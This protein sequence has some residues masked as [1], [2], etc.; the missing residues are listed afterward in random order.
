MHLGCW[1]RGGVGNFASF[2]NVYVFHDCKE[3]VIGIGEV[4][5]RTQSRSGHRSDEGRLTYQDSNPALQPVHTITSL[6]DLLRRIR[7]FVLS[8]IPGMCGSV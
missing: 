7:W 4:A 2:L 5:G 3:P 8:R 1:V 6:S